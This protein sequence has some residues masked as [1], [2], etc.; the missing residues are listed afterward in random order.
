MHQWTLNGIPSDVM[1]NTTEDMGLTKED[2]KQLT[3]SYKTNMEALKAKTIAEG[4]FAWQM[5]W[6]GGSP[7]SEGNTCPTPLVKKAS[8]ASDLRELCK[9]NSPAQTRAMMYSFGPGGCSGDPSMPDFK[10]DLANFLLVRG[11]HAWLGHAWLGCSK[12]YTF[13][14]ELNLDYGEPSQLCSE[15][16]EGS[17]IF[18]RNYSKA[19]VEMDCNKWDATVIMH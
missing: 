7:Q 14:A 12:Q 18:K 15:T 13:P 19:T 2:F 9:P 8:C 4:K 6:T 11:A 5:M 1:P 16:A 3:A 17:G 10:E